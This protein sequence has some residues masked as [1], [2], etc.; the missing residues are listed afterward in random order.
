[1]DLCGV[2]HAYS[3]KAG[4]LQTKICIQQKSP[5]Q[6]LSALNGGKAIFLCNGDAQGAKRGSMV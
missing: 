6:E 2:S 1:M 4:V 3:T 5:E